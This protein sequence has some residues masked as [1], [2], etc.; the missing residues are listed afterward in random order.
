MNYNLYIAIIMVYTPVYGK[1]ALNKFISNKRV[2]FLMAWNTRLGVNSII[3]KHINKDVA[4]LIAKKYIT[5]DSQVIKKGHFEQDNQLLLK[6]NRKIAIQ[7]KSPK[8]I[9]QMK[10]IKPL[11]MTSNL[12]SYENV[13]IQL[14]EMGIIFDISL[15]DMMTNSILKKDASLKITAQTLENRFNKKT[16]VWMNNIDEAIALQSVK[17]IEPNRKYETLE[18]TSD[19]YVPSFKHRRPRN[20]NNYDYEYDENDYQETINLKVKN[21]DEPIVYFEGKS[22]EKFSVRH[23]INHNYLNRGSR[24]RPL[25]KC[26]GVWV[27]SSKAMSIQW[28]IEQ[29]LITRTSYKYKARECP[30]ILDDE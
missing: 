4:R 17:Y 15:L 18:D 16:V 9:R 14:P 26:V 2:A 3:S 13:Y 22:N 5:L 20:C 24:I 29:M 28:S 1:K 8:K 10:L 11:F 25:I 12:T 23:A 27:S 19:I 21:I 30:I 6:R 7:V